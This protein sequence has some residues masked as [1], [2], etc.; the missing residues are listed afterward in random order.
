MLHIPHIHQRSVNFRS[1]PIHFCP[2]CSSSMHAHPPAVLRHRRQLATLCRWQS[3]TSPATDLLI[4]L[5]R[6]CGHRTHPQDLQRRQ[7]LHRGAHS[8]GGLPPP[9]QQ[10]REVSVDGPLGKTDILIKG[11]R[12]EHHRFSMLTK[13]CTERRTSPQAGGSPA[14]PTTSSSR[15]SAERA[16]R[17]STMS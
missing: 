2:Q 16:A 15:S 14:C 6:L 4:L 1:I 11:G 17:R 9:S 5:P 7:W 10:T 3:V 8:P 12:G 13:S